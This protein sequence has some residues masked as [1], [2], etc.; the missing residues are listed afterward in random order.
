MMKARMVLWVAA[1]SMM[2]TACASKPD[3]TIARAR[4]RI[5]ARDAV[6]IAEAEV[7]KRA[8][9]LP[10]DYDINVKETFDFHEFGKQQPIYVVVFRQRG[11]SGASGHLF[12]VTVAKLSGE[13]EDVLDMRSLVPIP[14]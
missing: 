8:L 12:Q 6:A 4:G 7:A 1:A 10:A 13:I 14:R 3:K 9:K 2:L 11:S 5:G